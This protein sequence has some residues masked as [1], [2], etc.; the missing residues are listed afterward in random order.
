MASKFNFKDV[1]EPAT[2]MTVYRDCYWLCENGDET[3]ALFSGNS[4]QCNSNKA[5]LEWALARPMYS[6][7]NL[8]SVFIPLAFAPSQ[9]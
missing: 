8:Q 4:P 2:G 7:M 5:I 6:N 1:T 3:K 9:D